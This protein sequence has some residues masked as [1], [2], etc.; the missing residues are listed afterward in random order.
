MLNLLCRLLC[1]GFKQGTTDLQFV[2]DTRAGKIAEIAANPHAH[3]CWYFENS[4]EQFR[5]DG[6]LQ[7][8]DAS[9]MDEKLQRVICPPPT[10]SSVCRAESACF[11]MHQANCWTATVRCCSVPMVHACASTTAVTA[12][13][14][15]RH[16]RACGSS[17]QTAH[18]SSTRG[19]IRVCRVWRKTPP[20]TQKSH[21]SRCAHSP[22][23]SALASGSQVSRVPETRDPRAWACV[24]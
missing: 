20:L 13:S 14:A 9:E 3:I 10:A 18:A 1:R 19:H 11:D 5:L 7:V 24:R 15:C 23:R 2:T 4:R 6:T 12:A 17:S 22:S 16:G 8:V 21:Q